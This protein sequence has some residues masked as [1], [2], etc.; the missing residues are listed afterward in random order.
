[1]YAHLE[2]SCSVFILCLHS[3]RS[4]NLGLGCENGRRSSGTRRLEAVLQ[5]HAVVYSRP[6]RPLLAKRWQ[7]ELCMK[8]A[9]YFALGG[10]LIGLILTTWLA[11]GAIAWY[12]N[13]PVSMGGFSCS[14]PIAWALKRLQWT[15]LWGVMVGGGRGLVV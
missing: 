6:Q 14:V 5:S 2:R 3:Y 1:R 12:F 11:P 8:N 9:L 4:D 15:Q 7:Q 10:V 13:P